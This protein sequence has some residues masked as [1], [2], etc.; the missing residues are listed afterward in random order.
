[1]LLV[2]SVATLSQAFW[3]IF[4][5]SKNNFNESK[6]NIYI[7]IG[8]DVVHSDKK[9]EIIT[10]KRLLNVDFFFPYEEIWKNVL[11]GSVNFY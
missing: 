2:L 6:K 1:M 10:E 9:I 8:A 5:F 4:L 7:Q 3:D 11:I